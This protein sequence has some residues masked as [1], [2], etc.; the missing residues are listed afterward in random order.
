M[1]E[2]DLLERLRQEVIIGIEGEKVVNS[3]HFYTMFQSEEQ[4]KVV[5]AGNN[6]GEVQSSPQ[7]I[8]NENI[9]LAA[10]IWKIKFIDQQ[11]KRIEVIPANDG[12]KPQFSGGGGKIHPKV[13]EKMLEIL[14]SSVTYDFLDELSSKE[15]TTL[16]QEFSAF[17]LTDFQNQRPLLI[18]EQS[19]QLYSFTGSRINQTIHHFFSLAGINSS[20]DEQKSVLKILSPYKQFIE[21]WGKWKLSPEEH[22]FRIQQ[23]LE[24]QP[25]LLGF[26]KWAK[27]LPIGYQVQLLKKMCFDFSGAEAMLDKLRLVRNGLDC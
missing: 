21:N 16:R 1:I 12:K 14:Y 17:Q 24:S 13:R 23:N 3:R 19:L 15:I 5:Y 9:F 4:F 18:I 22:D 2:T 7:L 25:N 11:T 27:F 20:L 8:E 6:I 10:R 26:S